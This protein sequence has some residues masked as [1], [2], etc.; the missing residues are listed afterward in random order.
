MSLWS[1]NF[2]FLAH[3]GVHYVQ[4]LK[5]TYHNYVCG[6]DMELTWQ[7]NILNRNYK[8]EMYFKPYDLERKKTLET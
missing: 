4:I 6:S 2:T 3:I 5:P 1:F 8:E 7:E